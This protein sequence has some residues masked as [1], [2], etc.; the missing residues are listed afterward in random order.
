MALGIEAFAPLSEGAR[1]FSPGWYRQAER[2][3][4]S[5]QRRVS[6][7][8]K[9]STRRRKAVTLLAKAHPHVRRQGADFHHQTALALVR[10]NDTIYQEDVQTANMVKNHSLAKSTADARWSVFLSI[11]SYKAAC[12]G[13]SVVAVPPAYTSQRC[14]GCGR[15]AWKGVA[16]RWRQRR[17]AVR[18][19]T[20]GQACTA[21]TTQ[22]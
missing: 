4:T 1:I 21:T 18:M 17:Y 13:R 8:T 9:G 5:A 3:L 20:A 6:R 10:E 7:R 14:S 22:P 16:V 12:A 11:R 15:V 2:A 19:R